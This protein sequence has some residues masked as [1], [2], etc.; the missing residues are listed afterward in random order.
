MLYSN[1]TDDDECSPQYQ[2]VYNQF[3]N[4]SND[5][6]IHNNNNDRNNSLCDSSN[7]YNPTVSSCYTKVL[8]QPQQERCYFGSPTNSGNFMSNCKDYGNSQ[9]F[10]CDTALTQACQ[11]VLSQPPP[12]NCPK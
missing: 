10:I 6:V 5:P 1:I 12:T 2:A 3:C 8:Q 9:G 11:N 7:C 4:R